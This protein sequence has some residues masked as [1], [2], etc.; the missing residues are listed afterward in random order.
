VVTACVADDEENAECT[1]ASET[2]TVAQA[3]QL[4][5]TGTEC[6]DFASGMAADQEALAY[7]LKG[8]KINAVTPGVFLY[9]SVVEADATA[10][11]ISVQQSA[12]TVQGS[13][14][15]PPLFDLNESPKVFDADCKRVQGVKVQRTARGQV[16]LSV[17][18]AVPGQQYYLTVKYDSQS[19]AST[20]VS[21]NPPFQ[22]TYSFGTH[23][24]GAA[25]PSAVDTL[26]LRR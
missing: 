2:V 5:P 8:T 25:T 24:A 9:W 7:R 1:T 3:G 14:A 11:N 23:V 19:I 17:S 21:Q 22:A 16:T 13:P 6:S 20:V 12:V 10:L 4:T 15:S 26:V 18:G